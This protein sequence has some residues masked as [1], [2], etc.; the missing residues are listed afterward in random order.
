MV[1][2]DVQKNSLKKLANKIKLYGIPIILRFAHEMNS[3]WYPWS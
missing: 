1:M 2:K 3:N